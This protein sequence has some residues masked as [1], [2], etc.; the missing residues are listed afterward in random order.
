MTNPFHYEKLPSAADFCGRKAETEKLAQLINDGKN[1]VLFGDR[2]YGKTSLIEHVFR[3]TPKK[4]LHAFVDLF[5]CTEGQ[6]VAVCIYEAVYQALPFNLEKKLKEV[7]GAFKRISIGLEITSTG[8]QKVSTQLLSREFEQLI[9]DAL[10][11]ADA[12]CEKH[13]TSLV[14]ALD[15]FQQIAEIKDKRVDAVL[16]TY[17]Q[18]LKHVSFI[19]SGSKKSIL[20]GLFIDKKQPLYGMATSIS[21]G[22]I[23][24]DLFQKFCEKRLG[25]A[26]PDN[27]FQDLYGEV[28]GQT[29]LILQTCYTLYAG[30]EPLTAERISDALDSIIADKDEEFKLLFNSYASQQ[31]KA[32]KMIGRYGGQRLFSER[33]LTEF[34]IK[35]Q[36]LHQVLTRLV[37]LGDVAQ[38]DDDRYVVSDV[39]FH[40][41]MVRKFG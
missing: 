23:E 26:F 33:G 8:S 32:L 25:Q 37:S 34:R 10:T 36:N 30:G 9:E 15:E 31:K 27:S 4:T 21:L 39:H 12:L 18:R 16:R 20:S 41:W 1:V 13:G 38:M 17:M 6:D 11:G 22:G 3:S 29:K 14:I 24:P 40:L 19:F 35:K 5:A 28:R 2:R 7:S